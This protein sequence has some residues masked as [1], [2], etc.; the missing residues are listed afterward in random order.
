MISLFVATVAQVLILAIIARALLSWFPGWRALTPV[1][2]LLDE[3]TNS[4]PR[5]LRRRLP[6]FGGDLSPLVTGVTGWAARAG[7]RGQHMGGVNRDGGRWGSEQ[8]ADQS[9]SWSVDR[10]RTHQEEPICNHVRRRTRTIRCRM[11]RSVL[12]RAGTPNRRRRSTSASQSGRMCGGCFRSWPATKSGC[13]APALV[14]PFC[15]WVPLWHSR[16]RETPGGCRRAIRCLLH[17]ETLWAAASQFSNGL[18]TDDFVGNQ[19]SDSGSE[20]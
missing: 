16:A 20:G 4:I 14:M 9:G 6:V 17:G 5:P 8:A 18:A 7:R 12:S 2:A 10:V 3:V 1:T 13:R 11:V 19:T 15:P